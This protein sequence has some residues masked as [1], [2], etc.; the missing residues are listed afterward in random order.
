MGSAGCLDINSVSPNTKQHAQACIEGASAHYVEAAVMASVPPYGLA[1]P[2]LIVRVTS[3]TE[4][5]IASINARAAGD[6]VP[7]ARTVRP[8]SRRVL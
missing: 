6:G 7:A 5:R 4:S 1:V 8:M 2:M 3:T